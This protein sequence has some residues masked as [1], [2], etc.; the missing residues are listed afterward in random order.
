MTQNPLRTTVRR[1]TLRAVATDA[2]QRLTEALAA[3]EKN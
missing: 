3:L 1:D 2:R